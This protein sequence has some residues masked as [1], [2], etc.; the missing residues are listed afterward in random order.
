MVFDYLQDNGVIG[1][2][3][4]ATHEVVARD[5]I[6]LNMASTFKNLARQYDIGIYT[7]TQLNGNEKT[8]DVIDESCLSGG[9]AVKNKLDCGCIS[10]PPRKAERKLTEGLLMNWQSKQRGNEYLTTL[11][12]NIV[13]HNY[14]TRF[15]KYGVG[16]KIYQYLD[17][18]TGRCIDMFCTNL[19][20]EPINVDKTI[21]E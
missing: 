16:V 1:K 8:A 19:Y 5:T 3:M 10:L 9:K 14:K 7:M 12:P 15:G 21:C 2:E 11:Q 6:I 17:K 13:L 18:G 4:R 20:D